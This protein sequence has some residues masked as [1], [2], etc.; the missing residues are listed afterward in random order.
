MPVIKVATAITLD[1][2]SK[3]LEE[4][5]A[6]LRAKNT[7][8]RPSAGSLIGAVVVVD[9]KKVCMVV[10]PDKPH[11]EWA[12]W[13]EKNIEIIASWLFELYDIRP[14]TKAEVAK[15]SIKVYFGKNWQT[16]LTK[17]MGINS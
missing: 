15:F 7:A 11:L 12:V 3:M 14:A 13:T 16:D 5:T 6:K 17:V 2:F 10:P 1:I 4:T 8:P 9:N